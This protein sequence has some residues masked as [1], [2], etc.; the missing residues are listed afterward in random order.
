VLATT[1]DPEGTKWSPALARE[2]DAV[3]PSRHDLPGGTP[4]ASHPVVAGPGRQTISRQVSGSAVTVCV[5]AVVLPF[6]HQV[7]D[8]TL[9]IAGPEPICGA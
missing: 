7:T 4:S 5:L 1:R 3:F 9:L 6:M 2:C 8:T